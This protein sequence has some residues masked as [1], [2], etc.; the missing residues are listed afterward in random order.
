M[1]PKKRTT[2]LNPETTTTTP[3][4]IFVTNAQLKAM[5][6]KALLPLWQHVMLTKIRMAMI[7]I[8]QERVMESVF[9]I[10]NCTVENQVKFATC[11]LH[12]VDLTWWNTYV[13]TVGH[14][15]AY[16]QESRNGDLGSEG[17]GYRLEKLYRWMFLEEDVFRR[18]GFVVREDVF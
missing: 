3:A 10:S 11:T 17:E 8:F 5:I 1:A 16:D 18:I 4:T 2:R 7:A 15:A 13:K 12:S 6:T 14:D 9:H